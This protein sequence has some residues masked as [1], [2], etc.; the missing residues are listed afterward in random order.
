MSISVDFQFCIIIEDDQIKIL[1]RAGQ[2]VEPETAAR[3]TKSLLI[4]YGTDNIN[5]VPA[6]VYLL[7]S[8]NMKLYKIGVTSQR[9]EERVSAISRDVGDTNL[10]IIQTIGCDSP[11]EAYQLEAS[12]HDWFDD[13]RIEGE[14]FALDEID[15][16]AISQINPPTLLSDI[17]WFTYFHSWNIRKLTHF[18]EEFKRIGQGGKTQITQMLDDE[19][20][21]LQNMKRDLWKS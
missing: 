15:I 9:I 2:E 1:D 16:E 6:V 18:A 14:W 13:V 3:I 19:I 20:E 12:L 5:P 11:S 8:P 4:R 17:G 21:H 7:F 10:Q